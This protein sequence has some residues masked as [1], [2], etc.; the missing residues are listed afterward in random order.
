MALRAAS[1]GADRVF[2]IGGMPALVTSAADTD[3]CRRSGAGIDIEVIRTGQGTGPAVIGTIV[4]GRFVATAAS[5]GFP[6]LART[7]VG[8]DHIVVGCV[9]AAPQGA[10]WCGIDLTPGMVIVYAPGAEHTGTN[11]EGLEFAFALSDDR[12][13]RR[14]GSRR[15]VNDRRVALECVEYAEAIGRIPSI[16][17]LCLVVHVSER[18]LRTAFAATYRMSP[19]RFFRVWALDVARMRLSASDP[20]VVTVTDVAVDLGISHVGRLAGRYNDLYGEGPSSTLRASQR[21]GRVDP[22]AGVHQGTR[23]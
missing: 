8:E 23:G 17:E 4:G 9:T 14:I 5:I 7:R 13:D 6:L 2:T 10:R 12:R 19:G 3:D 1:E 20:K 22:V 21:P 15:K 18:R 16:R 11:P